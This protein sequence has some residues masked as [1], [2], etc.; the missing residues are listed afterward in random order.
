MKVMSEIIQLGMHRDNPFDQRRSGDSDCALV[1]SASGVDL[2][3]GTSD[4]V[5]HGMR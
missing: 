1:P 5:D 3:M 2:C 4:D